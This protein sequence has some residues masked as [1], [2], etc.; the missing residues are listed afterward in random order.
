MNQHIRWKHRLL[1]AVLAAAICLA[2]LPA[3]ALAFAQEGQTPGS[4][5]GSSSES[6]SGS[7][8][9]SSFGSSMASSSASASSGSQPE[10]QPEGESAP[11]SS[12]GTSF[13]PSSEDEGG[14][15]NAPAGADVRVEWLPQQPSVAS[16]T[17]GTVTLRAQCENAQRMRKGPTGWSFECKNLQDAEKWPYKAVFW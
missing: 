8:S 13:A 6:A 12:T 3:Q 9:G 17:A 14:A 15:G 16:G 1:S 4:T 10:G 5:P 11:G 7:S 2:M